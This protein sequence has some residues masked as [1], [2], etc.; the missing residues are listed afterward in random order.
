LKENVEFFLA[1]CKDI[2][3]RPPPRYFH[4]SNLNLARSTTQ[5]PPFQIFKGPDLW[6]GTGIVLV[7]E[8]LVTLAAIVEQQY[9]GAPQLVIDNEWKVPKLADKQV[10]E[11]K[12][13]LVRIKD[14][15]TSGMRPKVSPQIVL[16]KLALM[17][18]NG[19]DSTRSSLPLLVYYLLFLIIVII[20]YFIY[21]FSLFW[22][23][24]HTCRR[25]SDSRASSA[26]TC[27]DSATRAWVPSSPS[28][29]LFHFYYFLFLLI[30]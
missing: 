25:S 27:S 14:K 6:E 28:T 15:P 3:V 18:G 7:I 16:K 4:L 9:E 1:A 10:I 26:A 12:K 23:S 24:I 21:F 30:L 19:V 29:H 17:A 13:Q 22:Q 2:G 5:V 8:S 20:H 11:I